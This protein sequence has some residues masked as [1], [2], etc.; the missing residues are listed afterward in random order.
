MKKV[1]DIPLGILI[2]V[3]SQFVLYG[4]FYLAKFPNWMEFAGIAF[5]V[6]FSSDMV[7]FGVRLIK[8]FEVDKSE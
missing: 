7:N 8:G 4:A 3:L 6:L 1:K 5:C 2:I